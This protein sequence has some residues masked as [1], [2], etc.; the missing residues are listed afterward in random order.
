MISTSKMVK[1]RIAGVDLACKVSQ[2]N[3]YQEDQL[4]KRVTTTVI[5]F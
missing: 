3:D 4:V 2:N 1:M 5:L